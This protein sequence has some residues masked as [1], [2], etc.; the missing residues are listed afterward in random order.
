MEQP[1]QKPMMIPTPHDEPSVE[2]LAENMPDKEFRALVIM[3]FRYVRD[4]HEFTEDLKEAMASMGANGG[5]M[6]K[7]MAG[8]MPPGLIPPP[9]PKLVQSHPH[10]ANGNRRR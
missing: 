4:I 2:E 9:P 10:T 3:T 7:M 6:G 1:A 8:M 5:M